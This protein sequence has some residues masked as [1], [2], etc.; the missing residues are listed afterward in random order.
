MNMTVMF[1]DSSIGAQALSRDNVDALQVYILLVELGNS[2]ARVLG[3]PGLEYY[4]DWHAC[5]EDYSL[6]SS[7]IWIQPDV[8][9]T[10]FDK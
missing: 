10:C 4:T 2:V 5:G 8:Q 3:P 1:S 7:H 9:C 6:G